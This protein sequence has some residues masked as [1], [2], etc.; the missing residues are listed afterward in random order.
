MDLK[1][2]TRTFVLKHPK[3]AAKMGTDGRGGR[4]SKI[5]KVRRTE[6]IMNGP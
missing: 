3:K 1:I 2:E 4:G 6:L 5:P